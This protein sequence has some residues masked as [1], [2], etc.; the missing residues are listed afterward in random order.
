[1]VKVARDGK[2]EHLVHA[3]KLSYA[4]AEDL[5]RVGDLLWPGEFKPN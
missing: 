5:L 1:M 4:A 3:Q 2:D